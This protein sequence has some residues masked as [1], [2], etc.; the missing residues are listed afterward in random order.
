MNQPRTVDDVAEVLRDCKSRNT[1]ATLLIGAGCSKSAGIPL[2]SELLEEIRE[3]YPR[4]YNHAVQKSYLEVMAQLTD[5][6]RDALLSKYMQNLRLNW[7]H[8]CIALLHANGFADRILTT[9]FDPLIARACAFLGEFPAIYDLATTSQFKEHA[10][11]K[12]S[13]FHLH[14]QADGFIKLNTAEEFETHS[15]FQRL[16]MEACGRGRPWLV[17]GYSGQNDPA[18]KFFE[19]TGRFSSGLYWFST[20][21]STMSA[22]VQAVFSDERCSYR[23]AGVDAEDF[24]I[25]LTQRLGLFPPAFLTRPFSFAKSMFGRLNPFTVRGSRVDESG[26]SISEKGTDR[27]RGSGLDTRVGEI[28]T[29]IISSAMEKIEKA[30]E[31]LETGASVASKI[32]GQPSINVGELQELLLAGDFDKLLAIGKDVAQPSPDVSNLLYW[33]AISKGVSFIDKLDPDNRDPNA[34]LL[35]D[36]ISVFRL[37]VAY[38]P[39]GSEGHNSLGNALLKQA[40]TLTGLEADAL[41]SASLAEYEQ[42]ARLDPRDPIPLVNWGNALGRM[43]LTL[44]S[45]KRDKLLRDAADK[46]SRAAALK[47]DPRTYSSW[48]EVLRRLAADKPFVQARALLADA[49]SKFARAGELGDRNPE[50]YNNWG[51]VTTEMFEYVRGQELLVLLDTAENHFRKALDL[52]PNHVSS[53][54]NLSKCLVDHVRQQ[55]DADNAKLLDEAESLLERALALPPLQPYGLGKVYAD[56]AEVIAHKAFKSSGKSRSTLFD[57]ALATAEIASDRDRDS[58][59]VWY[60]WGWIFG[61]MA[62]VETDPGRKDSL[63]ILAEEKWSQALSIDSADYLTIVG[64]ATAL[65]TLRKGKTR[66]ATLQKAES[67]LRLLL[68]TYGEDFAVNNFLGHTLVE[69]ASL[70]K[71]RP[72]RASLIAEADG[73]LR[74]A[75]AIRPG[76][77]A[78][79]VDIAWILI[80]KA[81]LD[82]TNR[83]TYFDE[84][85]KLLKTAN[86]IKVGVGA[87]FLA[88]MYALDGNEQG[89]REMLELGRESKALPD[90]E[91]LEAEADLGD[92]RS[93]QWFK[94]LLNVM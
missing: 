2:A 91:T 83:R 13:I 46:L 17:V 39:E 25:S 30:I 55:P 19:D 1:S 52:Q 78:P 42:A 7:E 92:F 79:L 24:L 64:W 65:L 33:A 3:G 69:I 21:N 84:A 53:I 43:A 59:F 9:N 74:K 18:F 88:C 11:A 20:K 38:K 14:G 8:I 89:C 29:D 77:F 36:A 15:R 67:L 28:E 80:D 94:D 10:I 63:L 54:L 57:R 50:T 40:T 47:D 56:L 87:Y 44:D 85:T 5:D 51:I 86:E 76:D 16:A 75:A 12:R 90:K 45:T 60:V 4:A 66:L 73:V 82:P 81:E 32:P 58:A 31:T 49:A 72:D 34:Q 23:V 48:G 70:D 61:L 62:D 37:A 93:R 26:G 27:R 41:F 22:R 71:T 68:P 35:V 6:Q